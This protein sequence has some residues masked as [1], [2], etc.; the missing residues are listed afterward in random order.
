MRAEGR[1]R[2]G[3]MTTNMRAAQSLPGSSHSRRQ[4]SIVAAVFLLMFFVDRGE[5]GVTWIGM[6]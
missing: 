6:S 4:F 3:V 1:L 2:S 5:C